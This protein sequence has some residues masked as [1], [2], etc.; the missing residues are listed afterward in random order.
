MVVLLHRY[1]T[2]QQ[3]NNT[4][5]QQGNNTTSISLSKTAPSFLY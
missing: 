1:I 4:T 3:C 2:I 5:I